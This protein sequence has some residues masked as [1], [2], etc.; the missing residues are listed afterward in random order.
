MVKKGEKNDTNIYGN[1][2]KDIPEVYVLG[3]SHIYEM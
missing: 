2:V 1:T 3:T